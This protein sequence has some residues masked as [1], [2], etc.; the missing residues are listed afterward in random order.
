MVKVRKTVSKSR[1][2]RQEL[3]PFE[4]HPQLLADCHR[5]GKTGDCHVL[6]HRNSLVP[7]FIV[8]PETDLHDVLDLP[9]PQ[10]G[11]V[12]EC[13]SGVA[14]VVKSHW[15]LS[16]TNFAGLGNVVPQLHLHVI[17]RS[18]Q[19]PCWPK[20]VWGNLQ[21]NAEYTAEETRQI[22]L[23][24]TRHLPAFH[25]SDSSGGREV[26]FTRQPG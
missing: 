26:C 12:I 5:L 22:T 15:R 7:W 18:S 14:A 8:V 3:M 25:P 24:L 23:K 11:A 9:E 13:C 6:L 10:R 1:A 16:K 21:G 4:I 17:G 19:D 20:P 2:N